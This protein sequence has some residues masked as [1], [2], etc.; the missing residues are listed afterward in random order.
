MAAL[1]L[2]DGPATVDQVAAGLL[3]NPLAGEGIASWG[4]SDVSS[5]REMIDPLTDLSGLP[6]LTAFRTGRAAR[7]APKWFVFDGCHRAV[8]LAIRLR[9]ASALEGIPGSQKVGKRFED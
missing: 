7:G 9:G 3:R 8:A 6:F 2:N 4:H 1:S 5:L